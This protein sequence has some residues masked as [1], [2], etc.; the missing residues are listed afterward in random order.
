MH[1]ELQQAMQHLVSE[2]SLN[3][4]EV[5]RFTPVD[6]RLGIQWLVAQDQPDMAQA[7]ADA[8][9]ALYPLSEDILAISGLLAITR[10]DWPLAV[11]ILQDLVSIQNDRVQPMTYQM[12]A[13]ALACNLNIPEAKDVLEQALKVWPQDPVLLAEYEDI[14]KA[15]AVTVASTSLTN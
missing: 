10:E 11:E 6:F 7:L 12:L 14:I 8:G 13:R 5:S 15:P 4:K 1:I 3:L 2:Q 9:I